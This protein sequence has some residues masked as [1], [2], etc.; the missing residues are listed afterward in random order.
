MIYSASPAVSQIKVTGLIGVRE[1]VFRSRRQ[2][3]ARH[4]GSAICDSIGQVVSV[5]HRSES[6]SLKESAPVSPAL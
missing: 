2:Q 3:V 4:R 5:H 6:F 1:T